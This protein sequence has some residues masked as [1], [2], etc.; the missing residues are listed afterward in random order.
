MRKNAVVNSA[1]KATNLYRRVS[2]VTYR[3]NQGVNNGTPDLFIEGRKCF[4]CLVTLS[5]SSKEM[6]KSG[7]K[8]RCPC[9]VRVCVTC[10]ESNSEWYF[11]E[12]HFSN[13]PSIKWFM[14]SICASFTG[15]QEK[16]CCVW[17]CSG[18]SHESTM[19]RATC[20]KCFNV[21]SKSS[22]HKKRMLWQQVTSSPH[23][24]RSEEKSKCTNEGEFDETIADY[25]DLLRSR[26][27][28]K[29]SQSR[30]ISN[31]D[32]KV[33]F[34]DP[35]PSQMCTCVSESNRNPMCPSCTQVLTV[36]QLIAKNTQPLMASLPERAIPGRALTRHV[37]N[38][39][40]LL[41]M[42]NDHDLP[43]CING[44]LCKGMLITSSEQHGPKQLPSLI[45]PESYKRF[46][47]VKAGNAD[48][49][50][51]CSCI[52]CLLFNQSAAVAQMLSSGSLYYESYPNGPVYYF[53][54]KLS[55]DVGVPEVLINECQG[56]L[57]NF[58]GIIGSY[59]PTFY[60]NWKDMLN[61]LYTDESGSVKFLP[62]GH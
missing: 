19:S 56:Y 47:M 38:R 15:L 24:R 53:N 20:S 39:A 62:D 12:P 1:P 57:V 2:T 14:C 44:H 37:Y 8:L 32:I 9:N 40:L 36:M 49:L 33:L 31:A 59:E 3:S 26:I 5:K 45:S 61:M 46:K 51:P 6:R 25:R 48:I 52:L 41:D 43:L 10:F 23:P 55:P 21:L 29:V 17:M 18:C 30:H 13:C 7:Y 54:L 50:S 28:D 35:H 4:V 22:S 42:L 27:F 58:A 60:Y 11:T 34:Q 16:V